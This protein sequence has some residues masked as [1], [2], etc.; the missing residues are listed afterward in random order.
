M[1][2]R[3]LGTLTLAM[4]VSMGMAAGAEGDIVVLYTNDVHCAVAQ[5]DENQVLGYAK[6]AALKEELEEAGS[7]VI[8]VDAGD[9]IQGEAIGTLSSGEYL[10][11]I[12]D[13]VGYDIAVPGNHEFD[14]GMEQFLKLAEE[15]DYDY[16]SANFT[17]LTTES[18][19]LTP[20]RSRRK[21]A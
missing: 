5:D 20:M 19:Y 21:A 3:L 1:K 18:R 9:A 6:V 16:I 14:Y 11:Q 12:M 7:E 8:L 17:D 13:E 15:A 10:V 4:A 2:K